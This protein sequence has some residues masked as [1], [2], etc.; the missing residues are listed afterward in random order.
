[1]SQE[2]KKER[3]QRHPPFKDDVERGKYYAEYKRNYYYQNRDRVKAKINELYEKRMQERIESYSR[4][5]RATKT[6]KK[7]HGT[8]AGISAGSSTGISAS[9]RE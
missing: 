3:K 4:R 1:M 5:P 2:T 6:Q 8:S 7:T 9:A